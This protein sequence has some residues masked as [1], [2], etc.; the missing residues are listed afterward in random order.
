[1]L[2]TPI[3]LAAAW[4]T[5]TSPPTTPEAPS[6]IESGFIYEE[7]PPTPSC[8]ASTIVEAKSGFLAAWFGGTHEKN[9]DVAIYLARLKD[10]R[11]SA[12]REALNGI[13][14]DGRRFPCWNPV[15]FRP[16]DGPIFLYSK[17][18]PSPSTWWGVVQ[19]SVD[20]GETWSSPRR[21]PGGILGPIKNK[22]VLLTDGT[23]LC[24]SSDE[25]DKLGWRVFMERTPDLGQTW[26]KSG[27]LN[28]GHKLAAIQ[29]SILTHPGG[30]LQIVARTMQ[31]KIADS[32]SNDLGKTWSPLTLMDIPN[33]DSGIDAVTLQDGRHLLVYNPTTDKRTPLNV[34]IS[35]DGRSWKDVLT[36]EDQPG[37]YSYPAVIQAEDK[38]VHITYTWKRERIKHVAIRP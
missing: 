36:L 32:W 31:D 23:L 1:M 14:A 33:P 8:H 37:E 38:T 9:P 10:G 15:L 6:V 3:L 16:E 35:P 2:A 4:T 22:P 28:D 26:Q 34:A 5:W 11:W 21:L 24:P 18:G 13:Q 25:D 17:V 12:P 29:P 20:D 27:P 7:P 30:R 19:T